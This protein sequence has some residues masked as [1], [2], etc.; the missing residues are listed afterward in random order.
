MMRQLMA[1]RD[2]SLEK[3]EGFILQGKGVVVGLGVGRRYMKAWML[4]NWGS[5][6]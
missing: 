6:H 4:G 2:L 5:F 3:R 1:L